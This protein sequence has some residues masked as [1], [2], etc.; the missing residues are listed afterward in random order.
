MELGKGLG[1]HIEKTFD[2]TI[3]E[4]ERHVKIFSK[5]CIYMS[6]WGSLKKKKVEV[7]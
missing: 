3:E 1:L 4:K 7:L 5:D 6:I 2:K